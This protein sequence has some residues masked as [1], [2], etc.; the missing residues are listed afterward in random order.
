MD[1]RNPSNLLPI[2]ETTT[3][4]LTM[5]ADMNMQNSQSFLS[6]RPNKAVKLVAAKM[7]TALRFCDAI[8]L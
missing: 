2:A 1:I 5:K 6:K 3:L 7:S 8:I 4:A